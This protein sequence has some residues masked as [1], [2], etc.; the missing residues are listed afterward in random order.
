MPVLILLV[1][2]LFHGMCFVCSSTRSIST[3]LLV[4]ARS[5]NG[6]SAA[7]SFSGGAWLRE[8]LR[9]FLGRRSGNF[10]SEQETAF[11]YALITHIC[12]F[13]PV[14]A[15]R[16][17]SLYQESSSRGERGRGGARVRVS[18]MTRS[19]PIFEVRG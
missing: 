9:E 8:E 12:Q 13:V 11:A 4:C 19:G 10:G 18:L 7:G 2:W 3:L 1:C 14:T 17:S 6:P 15:V 16:M 5:T